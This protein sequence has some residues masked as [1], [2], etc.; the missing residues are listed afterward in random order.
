MF[1]FHRLACTG[2]VG[3]VFASHGIWEANPE[4]GHQ[5]GRKHYT[6]AE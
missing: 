6:P 4:L 3:Y 5:K 1:I 2:V